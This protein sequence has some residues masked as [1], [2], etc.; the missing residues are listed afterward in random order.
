MFS[1]QL[2]TYWSFVEPLGVTFWCLTLWI[3]PKHL[4]TFLQQNHLV[5]F[6]KKNKIGLKITT[7]VQWKYDLNTG[8]E[9]KADCNVKV[10]RNRNPVSWMKALCLLDPSTSPPT[11]PVC[12]F[13][14]L[15]YVTTVTPG[16]LSRSV[17]CWRGW[18]YIVVNGEPGFERQ[19]PWQSVAIWCHGNEN[20]LKI[21]SF[22]KTVEINFLHV[23]HKMFDIRKL[24]RPLKSWYPHRLNFLLR[25]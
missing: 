23:P 16:A 10:K 5:R 2:V 12:L 4:L 19:D 25:Y 24:N 22:L 21:H 17:Y 1:F 7:F 15:N 8:H 13:R 11:C 18:V 9:R 20:G 14:C 3:N 6:R